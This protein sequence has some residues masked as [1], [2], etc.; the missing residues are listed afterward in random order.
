M[1]AFRFTLDGRRITEARIAY[2]GMAATPKRASAAEAALIGVS[3]DEPK[4]W[5]A[6]LLAIGEDFKPLTDMR[7]TAAYR[8]KVA[9]NLL[10]RA[11]TEIAGGY[12][13]T[14]IGALHAAE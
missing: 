8:S 5:D 14:R 12:G 13:V 10:L 2:G 6:A 11:V 4:A 9:A 7:A 1:S 3:L